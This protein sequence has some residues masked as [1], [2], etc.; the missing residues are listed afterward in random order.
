MPAAGAAAEVFLDFAG[1]PPPWRAAGA[2]ATDPAA[3]LWRATL[4]AALAEGAVSSELLRVAILADEADAAL[5]GALALD[6]AGHAAARLDAAGPDGDD[7]DAVLRDPA[8]WRALIAEGA[9]D[10]TARK[11][12]LPP[13]PQSTGWRSWPGRAL[14]RAARWWDSRL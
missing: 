13:P 5:L 8:R 10:R 2:A 7:L 14:R 11:A 12:A 9:A 4:R 3:A 1:R 6:P